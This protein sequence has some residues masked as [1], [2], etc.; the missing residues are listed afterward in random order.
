MFHAFKNSANEFDGDDAHQYVPVLIDGAE[1][2]LVHG[3]WFIKIDGSCGCLKLDEETKTYAI[4]RRYDAKNGKSVP[5]DCVSLIE[6]ANSFSYTNKMATHSYYMKPCPRPT[7]DAKGKENVMWRTLY[8]QVDK[9]QAENRLTEPYYSI[10]LVGKN[11][12]ATPNV[13]GVRIALH[14]EQ[15]MLDV[16]SSPYYD[17]FQALFRRICVEGVIVE[18]NGLFWKIRSSLFPDSLWVTA[19]AQALAPKMI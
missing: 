16:P 6:G 18:H 14:S 10:E 1:E 11:F 12:S 8:S 13:D 4:Y 9:A 5:T 3:K 19:R 2:A 17:W 7:A 15:T